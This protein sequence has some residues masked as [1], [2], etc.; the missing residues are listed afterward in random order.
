MTTADRLHSFMNKRVVDPF[1]KQTGK[2]I[3]CYLIGPDAEDDD[4]SR[5][6][7]IVEDANGVLFTL[8]AGP[9]LQVVDEPPAREEPRPRAEIA[10][11]DILI[12]SIALLDAR[13]KD[14]EARLDRIA[15]AA[16]TDQDS[17]GV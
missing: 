13:I 6:L 10:S 3:S 11:E 16:C 15:V 17:P 1:T 12:A 7:L 5:I 2:V 9:R 8:R 4:D 14:L